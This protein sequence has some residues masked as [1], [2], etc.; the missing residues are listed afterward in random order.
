[1]AR[2][3]STRAPA[4]AK[5]GGARKHA[6]T[7]A[8]NEAPGREGKARRALWSGSL[9]FGLLQIPVSVQPLEVPHELSFTQLDGRDLHP[10]G[11][12]RYN[13]ATGEEVPYESIVRGFEI[14]KGEFVVV[15]DEELK[16][17]NVE[18]TQ[19]IDIID[20]VDPEEI[21]VTHF[22][23]PY[24]LV[25][26]KRGEKAYALLRDALAEKRRAAIAT[27]VLR[28]R[29]H[30]AAVMAEGD[31]LLLELL[32]YPHELRHPT[33]AELHPSGE[34]AKV[35]SREREM[36]GELV[37]H[38]SGVWDPAKYKDRY[39]DDVMAV[40]EKKARTGESVSVE[41]PRAAEAHAPPGDLVSL[42]QKSLAATTP[43][44][45]HRKKAS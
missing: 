34:L 21:P 18:A 38:M 23:T 2:A 24:L 13:K 45:A 22:E 27:V 30:L 4:R 32:R 44:P 8:A 15:T 10:I 35:S 16:A 25:P 3:R 20:F 11:Y 33:S 42:L 41:V 12:R 14:E 1:M 26:G 31:A 6:P 17:A 19:S 5:N 28:T 7:P 40:I 9:G 39:R 29:Q 43:S 36:A 37:D